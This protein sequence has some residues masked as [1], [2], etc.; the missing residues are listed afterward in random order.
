M[1][2]KTNLTEIKMM[3]LNENGIVKNLNSDT[4]L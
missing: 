1:T 4:D 2:Y 3:D